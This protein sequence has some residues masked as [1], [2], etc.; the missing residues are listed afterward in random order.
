MVAS[1]R[2]SHCTVVDVTDS[3]MEDR[4]GLEI[5]RRRGTHEL[6]ERTGSP[7]SVLS[8]VVDVPTVEDAVAHAVDEE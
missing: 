5:R 6:P 7:G 4:H 3:D 2:L 8:Q 1:R